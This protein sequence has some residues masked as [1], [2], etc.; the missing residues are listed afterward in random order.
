MASENKLV[1]V[2]L[3]SDEAV[4]SKKDF[5]NSRL[6]LIELVKILSAYEL[7]RK[8]KE[9][10]EKRLLLK[11]KSFNSNIGKINNSFPKIVVPKKFIKKR[12]EINKKEKSETNELKV[13]EVGLNLEEELRELQKKI[14]ELEQGM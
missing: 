4:E 10:I 11:I 9:N 8:L 1:Y 13:Q 14:K 6:L 12:N 2:K 5:L 3:E 7:T